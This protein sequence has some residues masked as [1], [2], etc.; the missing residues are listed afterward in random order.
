MQQPFNRPTRS[1][2]GG[3]VTWGGSESGARSSDIHREEILSDSRGYF[4]ISL[5]NATPDTEEERVG[6]RKVV[7]VPCK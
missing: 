5:T 6:R 3:A 4:L 7:V 2:F 1:A